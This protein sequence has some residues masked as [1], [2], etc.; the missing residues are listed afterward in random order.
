MS[1]FIKV[2]EVWVPDQSRDHLV[3]SEGFYG[4]NQSFEARSRRMLFGP[5]EGLPGRAWAT[6]R[7]V[8]LKDLFHP[9]FRRSVIAQA[10]GLTCGVA[11]P[12]MAGEYL[13]AVLVI[14]CGEADHQIGAIEVWGD[15]PRDADRLRLV[16]GFYGSAASFEAHSRRSQFARG[17]GLP[18]RARASGMPIVLQDVEDV[19]R[20]SRAGAAAAVGIIRGLA[21]PYSAGPDH[22]YV[23]TLLSS[24]ETPIARRFEVWVPDESRTRLHFDSGHCES[25]PEFAA[26]YASAGISKV[27][28]A[29]G[30]VWVTGIPSVRDDIGSD[31]SIIGQSARSAGLTHCVAVPVMHAGMLSA[32]AAWYF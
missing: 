8:I 18:G 4:A 32:V 26:D 21:I 25:N 23:L 16:D 19:T 2:T 1:T 22:S 13:L 15:D 29:I 11:L 10:A 27:G 20:F 17:E 28:S 24:R 6:G 14:F 3:L 30:R 7:P 9:L 5:D 31:P 12:I